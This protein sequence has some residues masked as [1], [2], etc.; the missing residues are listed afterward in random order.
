M[1]VQTCA[2]PEIR[3]APSRPGRCHSPSPDGTGLHGK[4]PSAKSG[5]H[6][7]G[8]EAPILKVRM[9]R[10]RLGRGHSQSPDGTGL[11]GKH[12]SAKSGCHA[13]GREAPIL[14]VRMARS[15][16][17]KSIPQVR[18]APS[19]FGK[20]PPAVGGGACRN[21][22]VPPAVAGE[23]CRNRRRVFG[24]EFVDSRSIS[25]KKWFQT[26][27]CPT[28]RPA[29]KPAP[30]SVHRREFWQKRRIKNGN[31]PFLRHD[32]TSVPRGNGHR[33]TN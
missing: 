30:A 20:V 19:N 13:P 32:L 9:A 24:S 29:N 3:M 2:I 27:R 10:S 12:P 23:A 8:R 26:H 25:V 5:C 16:P 11:H 33:K 4:H 18:M 1:F 17:G 6:V 15:R 28:D 7:P 14:K 21:R 22:K 31:C